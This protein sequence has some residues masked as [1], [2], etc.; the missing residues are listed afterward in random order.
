M[1]E[2]A[3]HSLGRDGAFKM[4]KQKPLGRG[5]GVLLPVS[6][7]P[8]DYGIGSFGQAAYRSEEHTSEIQSHSEFV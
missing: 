7:L 3:F 4:K 1:R 5:A 8:S 6:C 2:K